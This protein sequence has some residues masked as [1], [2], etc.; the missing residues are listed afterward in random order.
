MRRP[1][2]HEKTPPETRSGFVHSGRIESLGGESWRR[3]LEKSLGGES[4]RRV[5]E[6]SLGG[7]SWRR[8]LEESLGGE[9]WRRV[10]EE[11]LGGESWPTPGLAPVVH[12]AASVALSLPSVVYGQSDGL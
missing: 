8:V 12:P 3:V 10:L 11:S 5:L 4:W 7:E 9:S 1:D 6:E 2:G